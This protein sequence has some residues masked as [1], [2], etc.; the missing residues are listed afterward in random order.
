M[1]GNLNAIS[2][3]QTPLY[4]FEKFEQQPKH[5]CGNLPASGTGDTVHLTFRQRTGIVNFKW[6]PLKV[7]F[8]TLLFMMNIFRFL[9]DSVN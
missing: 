5:N 8:K 3:C 1:P 2:N 4:E 9:E 7:C 6:C